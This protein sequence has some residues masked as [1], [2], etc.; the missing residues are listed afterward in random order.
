ML[1]RLAGALGAGCLGLLPLVAPAAAD[2]APR[3]VALLGLIA[4][5]ERALAAF[6]ETLREQGWVEGQAL[7][8]DAHW[9]DGQPERLPALAAQALRADPAVLVAVGA[10]ALVATRPLARSVPV[11]GVVEADPAEVRALQELARP[12]S[13]VTG[14]TRVGP[15]ATVPLLEL[16]GEFAR[17]RARVAVLRYGAAGSPLAIG[18]REAQFVA[19]ALGFTLLPLD[20]AGPEALEAALADLP[21]LG[22]RG[23]VVPAHPVSTQGAR[24]VAEA[25][26]RHRVAAVGELR[27][28]AE[29]G[30][31]AAQGPGRADLYARAARYVDRLLRGA[32]PAELPVEGATRAEL[33]VNLR[34]AAELGLQVPLS[35]LLR[36]E[37]LE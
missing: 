3:R 24:I 28:L 33:V 23:L 32:R 15:P 1:A 5:G 19:R 21:R 13:P 29:A 34:T 20:V 18:W 36:A 22:A 25:A 11:V 10:A 6:R 7:A 14:V 17:G 35:V 27:E 2:E 12:G 16:L 31:L 8:L 26:R 9:A 4:P 37:T 30:L